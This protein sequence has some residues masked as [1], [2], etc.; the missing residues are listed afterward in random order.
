MSPQGNSDPET[1]QALE[2]AK[3]SDSSGERTLI[4]NTKC[5]SFSSSDN[6]NRLL[7]SVQSTAGS[8]FGEHAVACF[9]GDDKIPTF[10]LEAQFLQGKLD[11]VTKKR[12]GVATLIPRLQQVSSR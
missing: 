5:D 12:L 2:I 8:S 1:Q 10:A 9:N 7:H 6:Y 11:S 4:V 3:S